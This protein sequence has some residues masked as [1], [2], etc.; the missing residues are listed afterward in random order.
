MTHSTETKFKQVLGVVLGVRSVM[1]RISV[2][3]LDLIVIAAFKCY[4]KASFS[5]NISNKLC[6]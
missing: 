3:E 1:S 6:N 4:K 2:E 5:N